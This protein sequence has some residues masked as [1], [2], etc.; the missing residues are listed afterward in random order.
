MNIIL[1]KK[2]TKLAS[3]PHELWPYEDFLIYLHAG[4]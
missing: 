1:K 3:L 2:Q 4:L